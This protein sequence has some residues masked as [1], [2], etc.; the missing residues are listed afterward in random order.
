MDLRGLKLIE[1]V[2][3][4]LSCICKKF[5]FFLVVINVCAL[6][7]EASVVC[8]LMTNFKAS[9]VMMHELEFHLRLNKIGLFL[10]AYSFSLVNGPQL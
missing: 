1:P 4:S 10:S 3:Q 8:A 6:I 9:A 5:F 2:L 7:I